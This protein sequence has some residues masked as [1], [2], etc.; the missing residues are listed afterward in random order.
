MLF[1]F[2]LTCLA[3]IFVFFTGLTLLI[4]YVKGD[5]MGIRYWVCLLGLGLF[6]SLG[7][8]AVFTWLKWRDVRKK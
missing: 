3:V 1:R 2:F 7:S 4:D 6:L 5:T 8:S